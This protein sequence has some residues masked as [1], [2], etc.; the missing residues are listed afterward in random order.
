VGLSGG[1]G[2]GKSAVAGRWRGL[3]ATVIDAD[4]LA[5]EVVQPGT[6]GLAAVV[7]AFGSDVLRP[8]GGLDR[9]ALAARVFGG[10]AARQRLNAIVHP[11]VAARTGELMAAAPPDAIVVHDVPLL[12]ENDLAAGYH[13]V[14]IV[15]APEEVR[16]RRL[17]ESRGLSDVD[18]RA[19]IRSQAGDDRRRRVADILLDNTGDLPALLST[20]DTLWRERLVP[21]EENL[22]AGRP[23][24]AQGPV[25]V[26]YDPTWPTQ[27]DRLAARLRLAGGN[28]VGRVDH[29]GS[30]AVPALPAKD[31]IDIQVTVDSLDEADALAPALTAAGFPALPGVLGDTPHDPPDPAAWG[32]RLHQAADPGRPANV[33]LRVAGSPGWRFALLFRDWL[34]ADDASRED[35]AAVKRRLAAEHPD[36][37]A[38]YVLAKEPWFA[39]AVP[40]AEDW[41]A[42]T[43]WRP[44]AR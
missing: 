38:A 23:A 32:K 17:V 36:A 13:L 41:A 29:I 34:R 27:F 12:V 9:S 25:V 22:R 37:R 24:A 3:G 10:D 18:A 39:A 31:V 5:R 6:P 30:T 1:I 21:Y 7:D 44:P 14:V 33:H 4:V 42:R 19:R 16:I 20:V 35:Y 8:D 40:A 43:G 26:G 11:L 28:A 15:L 2:A